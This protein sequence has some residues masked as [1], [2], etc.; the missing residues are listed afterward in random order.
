[1]NEDETE[2]LDLV[3]YPR[4]AAFFEEVY[5]DVTGKGR[6]SVT[7]EP[8]K[9][10]WDDHS[11]WAGG[12]NKREVRE[13][14]WEL[15]Q[16]SLRMTG[17]E[18]SGKKCRMCGEAAVWR[19]EQAA[20]FD[21]RCKDHIEDMVG[22]TVGVAWTWNVERSSWFRCEDDPH[23]MRFFTFDEMKEQDDRH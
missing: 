9:H 17:V 3:E 10:D 2:R 6:V 14:S 1:M 7:L 23:K 19:L 16:I 13:L 11:D 18:G 15:E 22:I 12:L 8:F 5:F 21:Y 20:Y 4:M